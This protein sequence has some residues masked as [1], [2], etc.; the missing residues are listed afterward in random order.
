MRCIVYAQQTTSNICHEADN[1]QMVK[2]FIYEYRNNM[3]LGFG[4]VR[5]GGAPT[6]HINLLHRSRCEQILKWGM[7][8]ELY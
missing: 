2:L 7:T 5:H 3:D 1:I 6:A 8:L 4:G